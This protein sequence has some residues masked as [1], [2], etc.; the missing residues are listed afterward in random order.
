MVNDLELSPTE[1]ETDEPIKAKIK[2]IG[3][4]RDD[5][6]PVDWAFDCSN[7]AAG[8]DIG[9][10][11]RWGGYTVEELKAITELAEARAETLKTPIYKLAE[12]SGGRPSTYSS[13]DRSW[14]YD[15]SPPD[16]CRVL[17]GDISMKLAALGGAIEDLR[18][19]DSALLTAVKEY[20]GNGCTKSD[21]DRLFKAMKRADMGT[22]TDD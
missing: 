16:P 10:E 8:L 7:G 22:T 15:Y 17:I 20:F 14:Q 3:S 18:E 21:R 4:F 19:S 6:S 11:P 1:L 9:D 2:I 13:Q 5:G 12:R